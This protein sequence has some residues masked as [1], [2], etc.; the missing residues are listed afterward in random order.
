M[1]RKCV[2]MTRK[3]LL[4]FIVQVYLNVLSCSK[5]GFLKKG[6]IGHLYQFNAQFSFRIVGTRFCTK[7]KHVHCTYYVFFHTFLFMR[8]QPFFYPKAFSKVHH[9]YSFW[10]IAFILEFGTEFLKGVKLFNY[11]QKTTAKIPQSADSLFCDRKTSKADQ[12]RKRQDKQWLECW[13]CG[14][15]HGGLAFQKVSEIL[16]SVAVCSDQ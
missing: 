12:N 9:I 14:D 4:L 5:N 8:Q 6:E 11:C 16:L 2:Q 15:F 3:E 7:Q 1:T 10:P 13:Q